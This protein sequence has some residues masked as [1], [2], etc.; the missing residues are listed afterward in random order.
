MCKNPKFDKG[1]DDINVGDIKRNVKKI[2]KF[3]KGLKVQYELP[4]QPTTKRTY[5]IND[6][7]S[8]PKEN[9]FTLND[10][11]NITVEE[12][13]LKNKNYKIKYPHIP[14]LWVGPRSVQIHLPPEVNIGK[15]RD[16]LLTGN[17]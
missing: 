3:L 13:F 7:A 14:C 9:T 1:P 10:G 4:D 2:V 16:T 8:S 12:Y 15:K 11:T 5:F 17:F 6:L